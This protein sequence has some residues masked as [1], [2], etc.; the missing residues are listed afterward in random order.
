MKLPMQSQP[1]LRK[2]STAKII[3]TDIVTS[4]WN[5]PCNCTIPCRRSR[6]ACEDCFAACSPF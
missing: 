3:S 6:E 5:R 1:I 4:G 2:V